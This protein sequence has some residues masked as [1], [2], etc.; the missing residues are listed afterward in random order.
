MRRS[1]FKYY[2]AFI[3]FYLIFSTA[4][5]LTGQEKPLFQT[6]RGRVLDLDS[7]SPLE[8][9]TVV[10]ISSTPQIG[11]TTDRNGYF[12]LKQVAVGRHDLVFSY[13]GY[14]P[15]SVPGF[16]LASG[17]ETVLNISME[18]SVLGIDEIV[19]KPDNAGSRT[20]NDLTTI[21]GWS[22]SAVEIENYPGSMSDISRVA[23]SFPGVM[24][25]HDG[26]NHIVI[27]GNSPKGLQWRLEG[28][29]IP[30]LN[31]FSNIGASGGGV[32]IISNNMIAKSDFLTSAFPA[33]YGNALSGVFDLRLRSGNNQKHERTFQIGMIGTELMMEGPLHKESNS[34]Y[35]IH[36]R[37]STFKLIEKLGAPLRNVPDYQDLTFK[38]HHP[39]KHLGLFSFFGIGGLSK[40]LGNSG[41][42][43]K[44]N[45][46]L[47]GISNSY[48]LNE[49]TY[50]K[51]V[52]ALSGTKY[53][54]D[55]VYNMG[56][57]IYPIDRVNRTNVL[58]SSSK[59]S[60]P[61][62]RKINAKHKI[63]TGLVYDFSLNESFIG[64]HS[65]T[66]LSWNN[67]PR[68]P[69]YQNIQHK[70]V[71]VDDHSKAGTLQTFMNWKYRIS[72]NI[73]LNSGLH[74]LHFFLNNSNSL[75][76]RIGAKWNILPRHTISAAFGVHSRKE[77]L[78]MYSGNHTLHDGTIIQPNSD[79]D[80]AKARHY[81]LGYNF[82]LNEYI[83]LK[84]EA[85]YQDLYDIPAFAYP[86]YLSSVNFD[87]GFEDDILENYGTAF[88]RGIEMTVDK[89]LSRGFHFLLSGTLYESKFID[90][91]GKVL[92]TKYD[93]RFGSNGIF[94][95]E[96]KLGRNKQSMLNVNI[97]YLL[98]G[99]MRN[100]P[101]DREQTIA[102]GSEV[103]IWDEGYSAKSSDYFRIDLQIRF[104]R[105]RPKHTG[106]WCLEVMNLTN[107]KNL[108]YEYWNDNIMDFSKELQ[109]PII[110]LIK[111]RIQF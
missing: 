2:L 68:H 21:S 8:A 75:E 5:E 76:P 63:K 105:N 26:R 74:Y 12:V 17:K 48:T 34:T 70:Y 18:E 66:L 41:Y 87:F 11:T 49:K 9:V 86:P 23:L 71:N 60:I 39:T 20:V 94:S 93:G 108:L 35:I 1:C 51:S 59:L 102:I 27:R 99:G 56:S 65:D 101:I 14:E 55:H 92:H 104:I 43:M 89:Q 37:Y 82:Q 83:N 103:L 33:E 13:I 29:E 25:T 95:K 91:L 73:S 45:L 58:D 32:G 97:R 62:N 19:I 30:N 98:I 69:D 52:V 110:P 79:L 7:N 28:I 61:I 54:W 57:D 107:R 44:S 84:T 77:S 3:G 78:T 36:Y 6:I 16:L 22:F 96:F 85:Y 50:I 109:N 111:Y 106:E 90:K 31:H 80:L 15:M 40:E 42:I 10:L 88:N 4:G 81:V 24:S 100:L 72:E 38:I 53:S 64:W 47:V 67:N 46:G